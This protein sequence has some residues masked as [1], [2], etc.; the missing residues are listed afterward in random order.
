MRRSGVARYPF[1]ECLGNLLPVDGTFQVL[2][3]RR[4]AYK[5]YFSKNRRHC[6]TSQHHKRGF[7]DAAVPNCGTLGSQGTVKRALH[8]GSE[9]SRFLNLVSKFKARKG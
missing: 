7:L 4:T 3:V 8:T 1:V 6:G 5:R 9:P 2:L